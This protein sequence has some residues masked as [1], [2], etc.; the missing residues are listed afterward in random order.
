M[1]AAF[2]Q[3]AAALTPD[4]ELRV[5]RTLAAVQAKRNAGATHEALGL[6]ASVDT[7][8]LPPLQSARAARLRA[9]VAYDTKRDDTSVPLLLQAARRMAPC[10]TATALSVGRFGPAQ[11]LT[12]IAEAVAA[13]APMP[14]PARPLDLLLDGLVT[15]AT[16]GHAA[17]APLLRGAVDAYAAAQDDHT[18]SIWL[19]LACSAALDVWDDKAWRTLAERQVRIARTDGAIAALP[20]ALSYRALAHLHTGQLAEA[21]ALVDEV[22]TITEA[23]GVPTMHCANILLCAW[24][25]ERTHTLALAEEAVQ[26]TTECV[27]GRMLTAAEHATAVLFNGLGRYDA[28]L[29]ACRAAC[30]LDEHSFRPLVQP[31][32]VEAAAR[33]AERNL[34]IPAVK[35]LEECAQV[36][37]TPW[38]RGMW[39][40]SLALVTRDDDAE[41]LYQEA[42][43]MLGMTEST[44]HHARARLVYGEWLRRQGRRSDARGHLGAAHDALESSGAAAFAARASR[45]LKATGARLRRRKAEAFEQLTVQEL[46]IARLVAEGLTSKEV[47]IQLFLSPRTIDA[48]LRNIF[49]KLGISS[50]RQLRDV[51]LSS[52][53]TS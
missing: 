10:D 44:V 37:G 41:P 50:R 42:I 33:T 12:D 31:E 3:L 2:L 21:A 27:K 19:W 17:A 1:A 16:Q 20:V 30:D 22:D 28:A 13:T 45:E 7:G 49:A 18:A 51:N 24:R 32:F 6:L 38:A 14:Q 15:Q 23:I 34:A 11:R 36:Y 26:E 29:D 47:G 35:R 4:P 8:L 53:Q 39:L 5:G 43:E 25:G 40:R 52:Q 48:H 46:R 9:Q